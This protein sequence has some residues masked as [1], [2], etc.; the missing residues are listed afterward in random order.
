MHNFGLVWKMQDSDDLVVF[1]PGKIEMKTD[2]LRPSFSLGP[3]IKY[4]FFWW[5]GGVIPKKGIYEH[6]SKKKEFRWVNGR[7]WKKN[8]KETSL[9]DAPWV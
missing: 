6:F 2:I 7:G 4:V 1:R 9:M 3:F 5:E 8:L